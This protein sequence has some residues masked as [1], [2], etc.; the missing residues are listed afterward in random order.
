MIRIDL[1]EGAGEPQRLEFGGTAVRLG[2]DPG[3][4]VVLRDAYVSGRHGELRFENG[5]LV[6]EDFK[7]TNGS[8]LKRDGCL[9]RLG[10]QNQHRVAVREGDVLLLGDAARPVVVDLRG[11]AEPERRAPLR[12]S[13][14]FPE[15][16]ATRSET[17][18]LIPTGFDREVLLALHRLSTQLSTKQE[19]PDLCTVL[20][21][22]LLGTFRK[23]NHVAIFLTEADTG[24]F[25]PLLA[26][27]RA[28]D[29]GPQPVSRTVR[30]RV[31]AGG[32]AVVFSEFDADFDSSQSLHDLDVHSGLAAPLWNGRSVLGL[33]Q[34]DCRGAEARGFDKHDLEV[35][36]VF[37]HQTALALDNALLHD[38]LRAA[39]EQS[40]ASLVR[41]LEAKDQYTHGHS[42][43]VAELC[44]RVAVRA[45]M[46]AA[47]A[48]MVRRAA[49]LHDIG[50]IGIPY[51]V[52]NKE[53][54]LSPEEFN[55]LKTH[56]EVGARILEPFDFL[57]ALVPAVLHHHE[58][59]DGRG[60]PAGLAG[61]AIPLAARIL[62][63]V[64]TYHALVSDRAYRQGVGADVAIAELRRCSGTQFDPQVVEILEAELLA[65]GELAEDLETIAPV[66]EGTL[67]SV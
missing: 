8:L 39:C 53:G 16:D 30:D 24:H 33:V 44:E 15:L 52:L 27:G 5:D 20:A 25:R 12:E 29:T 67:A 51:S 18:G 34:L 45:G 42:E 6:F 35:L 47:E 57:S 46:D 38:R 17:M 31:L 23:A 10:E 37:A 13:G 40:I 61:E 62:S 4:D 58:R 14:P 36:V 63:V 2:R 56:P 55:L 32:K 11:V 43:A 28:G 60:Y 9:V 50:K 49:L 54:R 64:D 59:W 3:N 66:G 65:S 26:R 19:I 1:R 7:T 21:D 22:A 41:A 48:E